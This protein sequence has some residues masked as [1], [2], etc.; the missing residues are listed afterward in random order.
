VERLE[1]RIAERGG[2]NDAGDVSRRVGGDLRE[3]G[4][5][6]RGELRE[7]V[8]LLRRELE[9][10]EL[11]SLDHAADPFRSRTGGARLAGRIGAEVRDLDSDR[12]RV[13]LR[14]VPGLVAQV[15]RL[16]D[17]PIDVEEEVHRESALVLENL[18]A[19]LTRPRCVVVQDELVDDVAEPVEVL[20]PWLDEDAPRWAGDSAAG[21]VAAT[22]GGRSGLAAEA[23]FLARCVVARWLRPED[24]RC[25]NVEPATANPDLLPSRRIRWRREDARRAT[26][27]RR[28][29][30]DRERSPSSGSATS[31]G[32]A[33]R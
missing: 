6:R 18:E 3:D 27:G 11:D 17:R 25:P 23:K 33:P 30:E 15:E 2:T 9:L 4:A 20:A 29:E 8:V 19:A 13:R 7:G 31:V 24:D 10:L 12:A 26:R 21:L 22:L 16:V 14:R 32:S 1:L 5:Q 28:Q